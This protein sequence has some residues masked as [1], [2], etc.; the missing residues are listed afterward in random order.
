MAHISLEYASQIL[1]SSLGNNE[2][3]WTNV[4]ATRA[5]NTNKEKIAIVTSRCSC[6]RTSSD[7]SKDGSSEGKILGSSEGSSDGCKVNSGNTPQC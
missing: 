4:I 5:D 7:G 3:Y 2:G 6:V 1:T